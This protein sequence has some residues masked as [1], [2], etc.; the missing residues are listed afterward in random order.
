MEVHLSPERQA[1]LNEYAARRGQDPASALDEVLASAL[2]WERQD[3]QEA[4]QGIRLG[5]ADLQ[6]GRVRPAD[7]SFED[8]R[9]KHGLPR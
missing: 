7:E 8:L 4:V 6:A 3:Y 2:D 1:Q 9:V 5:Y